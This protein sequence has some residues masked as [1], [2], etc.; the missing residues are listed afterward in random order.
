MSWSQLKWPPLTP[1][2]YS[3]AQ[4]VPRLQ[5]LRLLPAV[6]LGHSDTQRQNSIL[7]HFAVQVGDGRLGLLAFGE[8]FKSSKELTNRSTFVQ[9]DA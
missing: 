7:Q 1:G 2:T 6:V 5:I 4:R 3:A 9:I 8:P